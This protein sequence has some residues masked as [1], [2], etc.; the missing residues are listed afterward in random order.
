MCAAFTA[1]PA[2]GG[3]SETLAKLRKLSPDRFVPLR[4][5]RR[6]RNAERVQK[7]SAAARVKFEEEHLV[8]AVYSMP[9]SATTWATTALMKAVIR[10]REGIK[11][12]TWLLEQIANANVP[13]EIRPL[14]FDSKRVALEKDSQ[15]QLS[16]AKLEAE[17][18][19][20]TGGGAT[21]SQTERGSKPPVCGECGL[22]HVPGTPCAPVCARL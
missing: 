15:H 4:C 12:L 9:R 19:A 22:T 3:N 6:A 7:V 16:I 11:Q 2:A 21:G 17:A 14:L 18:A 1:A 5:P 10:T 13:A 8:P 20:A